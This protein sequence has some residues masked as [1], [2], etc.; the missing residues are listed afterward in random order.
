MQPKQLVAHQYISFLLLQLGFS[1][2]GPSRWLGTG[3]RRIFDMVALSSHYLQDVGTRLASNLPTSV[4]PSD[5]IEWGLP[6]Q[7]KLF[8]AKA[9]TICSSESSLWNLLAVPVCNTIHN[10]ETCQAARDEALQTMR[11]TFFYGLRS[12]KY[13]VQKYEMTYL[14]LLK[15]GIVYMGS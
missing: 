14:L 1:N 12:V 3:S 9:V 5:T 6:C 15:F 11:K 10:H 7:K 13:L 4:N 8:F 2:N